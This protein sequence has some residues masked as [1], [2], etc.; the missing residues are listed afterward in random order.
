MKTILSEN[1]LRSTI[2]ISDNLDVKLLMPFV[3][4]VEQIHLRDTI[5]DKAFDELK[6]R[7]ENKSLDDNEKHLVSNYIKPYMAWKVLYEALPWISAQVRN[8]GIVQ[9]GD[10]TNT[11]SRSVD[12]MPRINLLLKKADEKSAAFEKRLKDYLCNF[13]GEYSNGTNV[14]YYYT[15]YSSKLIMPNYDDP[16]KTYGPVG[17]DSMTNITDYNRRYWGLK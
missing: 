3:N 2:I 17:Y 13:A 12:E 11:N 15:H 7:Y 4:E 8:K 14:F 1:Y 6:Y 10:S 9:P 16:G 5:G